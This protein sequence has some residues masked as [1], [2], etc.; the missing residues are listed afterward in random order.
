MTQPIDNDRV[1]SDFRALVRSVLV[2]MRLEFAGRFSY[3]IQGVTGSPPDT[4]VSCTPQNPDLGLPDLVNVAMSPDITGMTSSP[5]VGVTCEVEFLDRDPT[6]PR[7]VG[8]GSLGLLPVARLGDQVMVF[9]PPAL[10]IVG[11]ASGP[12]AG[13]FTGVITVANPVSG[14]ITQGSAK[15]FTG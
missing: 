5:D 10:P 1:M 14:V 4:T 8:V 15:C 11:A 3:T 2:E 6:Q 7:I 9:L 12:P 13:P